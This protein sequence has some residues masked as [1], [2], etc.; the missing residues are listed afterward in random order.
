MQIISIT[1]CSAKKTLEPIIVPSK[2]FDHL[3]NFFDY[4]QDLI[5][6]SNAILPADVLYAGRGIK[7]LLNT[8]KNTDFYIVSAGLGLINRNEIIP[9][10]S[11]TISNDT[12]VSINNFVHNS[13]ESY[14]WWKLLK[15]TKYSQSSFGNICSEKDVLLISLTT[16]Y[17][18][19]LQNE[20]RKIKS[21][22][23][24]FTGNNSIL[25]N[26]GLSHLSSPYTE[27]FDGP[28]GFKKGAKVDF[29][30]RIH[31]DF[32]ERL[33]VYS[34]LE[35]VFSSIEEDMKKWRKPLVLNNQKL[36]D[37]E[38]LKIIMD[39]I[40]NFKSIGSLH[41]HLRHDLNIA[42]EQKRFTKLFKDARTIL[43]EN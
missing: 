16:P 5:E 26:L 38:I 15:N 19:M 13:F 18:L 33:N 9:S 23:V 6:N 25:D 29:A 4:W 20:L 28:D 8:N 42:C 40:V 43:N 1:H 11:L 3:D 12:N 34:S 27:N 32:L 17:L 30:Q 21:K 31:L 35:L 37:N 39:K 41:K 7:N 24:I 10:Y 22:V 2:I 36:S 14:S